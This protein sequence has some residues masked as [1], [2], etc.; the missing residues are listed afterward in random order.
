MNAKI[1]II[2]GENWSEG[3]CCC[4]TRH[5]FISE[6]SLDADLRFLKLRKKHLF[7]SFMVLQLYV[8]VNNYCHVG[9]LNVERNIKQ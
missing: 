4:L 6:K 3:F 2:R 9:T 8:P 1:F 7:V 5:T